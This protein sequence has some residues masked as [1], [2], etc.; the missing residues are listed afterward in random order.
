MLDAFINELSEPTQMY[1]M[2]TP[3]LTPNMRGNLR[4]SRSS[5]SAADED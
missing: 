2:I 3:A 1:D 4:G 5:S